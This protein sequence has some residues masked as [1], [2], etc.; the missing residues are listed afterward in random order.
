MNWILK[1][2]SS[3]QSFYCPSFPS[4]FRTAFNLVRVAIKTG[5]SPSSVI[6]G[7]T[8]FGPINSKGERNKYTYNSAVELANSQGL[9]TPDGTINSRE[10][11]K[12]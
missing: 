5:K 12:K 6:K 9:L 4:A 8:I 3:G 2:S 11:K 7:I 10:F 1:N